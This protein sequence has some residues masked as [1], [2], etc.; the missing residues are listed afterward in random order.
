M[1][2]EGEEEGERCTFCR[3]MKNWTRQCYAQSSPHLACACRPYSKS[4]V[5][6]S[7]RGMIALYGN[8]TVVDVRHVKLHLVKGCTCDEFLADVLAPSTHAG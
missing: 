6:V 3:W 4:C 7:I 1:Q 8:T 2:R 5:S